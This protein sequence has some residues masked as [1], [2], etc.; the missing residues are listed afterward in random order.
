[1]LKQVNFIISKKYQK[2]LI[3]IFFVMFF[4]IFIEMLSVSLVLPA[5]NFIFNEGYI[6]EQSQLSLIKN[7]LGDFHFIIASLIILFGLYVLKTIVLLYFQIQVAQTATDIGRYTSEKLYNKYLSNDFYFFVQNKTSN[8]IRNVISETG[9]IFAFIFHLF[10]FLIEVLVF[11]GIIIVLLI[12]QT[13]E[14]IILFSLLFFIVVPYL[15]INKKK[16]SN[17]AQVR[18]TNDGLRLKSLQ[19]GLSLIK[20]IKLY[21]KNNFFLNNYAIPNKQTYEA[22][23]KFRII[24]VI[25]RVML[26]LVIMFFIVSLILILYA[27]GLQFNEMIPILGLYLA[28]FLR[29]LPSTARIMTSF[30]GFTYTFKCIDIVYNELNKK[31]L[32]LTNHLNNTN[33]NFN[34]KNYM[35]FKNLTYLYPG[36]KKEIIKNLNFEIKKN[37]IVGIVGKSGTGKSTLSNLVMGF[38]KPNQGEINVDGENINYNLS[39]WQSK[40]ACVP[41]NIT[42][43]DTS[44][45]ENIALGELK[46]DIDFNLLREVIKLSELTEFI[47][48][49]PDKYDTNV[50]ERGLKISG[51]QAQRIVLARSLYKC[52]ELLILDEATNSLDKKTESEIFNT[53]IKL[54]EKMTIL[55]IS[56]NKEYFDKFDKVINL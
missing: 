11:V 9:N 34:F 26:E 35:E 48:S 4:S 14:T 2:K 45:C 39:E 32:I 19:Q 24:Q 16:I 42:L 41:Q 47:N 49:L 5:L 36:T 10:T 29:I 28:A 50:G 54:K 40:V 33:Q 55:V 6:I 12:L 1:M 7:Q 20:E 52:P 38:L 31:N 51:G 44:I 15:I 53:I 37:S 25:P 23:K 27:N 30:H 13:Q 18:I 56:H 46:E 21:N 22:Q 17:I 8:L 43:L 3:F